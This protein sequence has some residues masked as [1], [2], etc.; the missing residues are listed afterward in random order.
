MF[1]HKKLTTARYNYAVR[2]ICK[3]EQAMKADSL[4]KKLLH[5][6]VTGFWKEVRA[7]NNSKTTLPCTVEGI[8]GTDNIAELWRQHHSIVFNGI[9]SDAYKVGSVAS[10][11]LVVVTTH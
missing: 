11:A 10:N 2:F 9:Q 5:N 4:A 8:S 3:N 1:G 7:L 6:N